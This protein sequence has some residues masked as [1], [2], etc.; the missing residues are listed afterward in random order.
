MGDPWSLVNAPP[1]TG[2][3]SVWTDAG[4]ARLYAGGLLGT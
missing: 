4:G 1:P 3:V 2:A